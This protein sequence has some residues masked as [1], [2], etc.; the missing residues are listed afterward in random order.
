MAKYEAFEEKL[1][2]TL[3]KYHQNFLTTK[4]AIT[5]LEEYANE[6]SDSDGS[7]ILNTEEEI[8]KA[9]RDAVEEYDM[10][11]EH[12]T[13]E[14]VM[15]YFLMQQIIQKEAEEDVGKN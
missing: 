15:H 11:R 6:T 8:K 7:N 4:E 10:T 13:E 14:M 1:D 5:Q 2:E 12:I 9:A 3:H